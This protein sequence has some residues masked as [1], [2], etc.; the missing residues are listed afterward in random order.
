MQRKRLWPLSLHHRRMGR[1]PGRLTTVAV[2]DAHIYDLLCKGGIHR[3]PDNGEACTH[4]LPTRNSG[5]CSSMVTR[6]SVSL[7]F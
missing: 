4:R 5:G 6:G 2:T 3:V 7:S 1:D